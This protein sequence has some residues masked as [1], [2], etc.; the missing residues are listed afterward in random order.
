[1]TRD[2]I[3]KDFKL[4]KINGETLIVTPGIFL[5]EP[6][7]APNF[8]VKCLNGNNVVHHDMNSCTIEIDDIDREEF[9]ELKNYKHVFCF[10]DH[11]NNTFSCV[12]D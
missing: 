3:K 4:K 5:H 8:Y 1:M 11:E 6:V 7:Y 9:P 2:M 10:I 12:A